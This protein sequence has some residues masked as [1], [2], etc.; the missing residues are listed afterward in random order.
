MKVKSK[1]TK[2]TMTNRYGDEFVFTL[3]EN[4]NIRWE[5]K[6]NY[7]RTGYPNDYL[8]AYKAYTTNGGLMNL[9]EFK[10]EVHRYIYDEND[11]YVGP[12]DIARVYGPLVISK[13]DVINMVDP[14]GGPYLAEGMGIMGKVIKEFKSNE[15]GYLIITE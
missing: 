6:F 9:E 13:T 11:R 12:C 1:I 14:S 3:L 10:K 7:H 2:E 4:G 5:G 8:P 15:S